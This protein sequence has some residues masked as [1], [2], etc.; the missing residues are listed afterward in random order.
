MSAASPAPGDAL[1]LHRRTFGSEA[2]FL[3]SAPARV[4]LIG[5][6]LDYNGGPV[7]PMA[8]D[9][10]TWVTVGASEDELSTM[11]SRDEPDTATIMPHSARPS[12]RWWDYVAGVAR[13]LELDDIPL[14]PFA[15]AVASDI[16]RGGGLSSSAALEVACAAALLAQAG[17]ADPAPEKIARIAHR[18]EVD[19][20]GVPCGIMDQYA[21]A[22]AIEGHA[23]YLESA[24]GEIEH[25]PLTDDV[26]VFDTRVPRSLR[27][28]QFALRRGECDEALALLRRVRPPLAHLA[29][30]TLDDLRR[31][32]LPSPLDRRAQHVIQETA[33]V[34]EVVAALRGGGPLRGSLLFE[35][36][37][38]LRSLYECSTPELDWFVER[39]RATPGVSGAR[40]TGA[41]WGGCAVATGSAPALAAAAPDILAEYRERFDRDGSTWISR[42]AGGVS[43][44]TARH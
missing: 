35:S 23:L 13:E 11:V 25:V 31:A 21:S 22:L 39:M 8:I 17:A 29:E 37:E 41:G 38:S 33:R 15:L 42:A 44:A 43:V 30:A 32:S 4:N 12:G 14:R 40:L 9:L 6:H 36:H 2:R 7:L 5:E 3:A 34:R 19:Y 28:S 16:P 26:L 18:A 10:R 24:T 20:V 1:E 27:A